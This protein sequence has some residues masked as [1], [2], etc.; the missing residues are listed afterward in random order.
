MN[1]EKLEPEIKR[2][3]DEYT[4]MIDEIDY[5]NLV[6]IAGI[7]KQASQARN[8]IY[9]CGNGGSSSLSQH[10]AVDFGVGMH[11]NPHQTG[12]RIFDLT[13][14]SAVVTATANDIGFNTVFSS[15]LELYGAKGD[16]L[17][18]ISASGKSENIVNAIQTAKRIGIVT[19][20]LIGFDGGIVK[21]I[22]DFSIHLRTRVGEYGKV[23][24]GHSF[25]LHLLRY[26]I[27]LENINS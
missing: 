13:S 10:F 4:Q 23:E 5:L 17:I 21:E 7:I 2:Y 19:I 1:F 26:L 16:I 20:G 9:V 11:R 14:N 12:L 3:V 6:Q 24:D 8:T 22:V 18:A 25:V 15:Q 27:N